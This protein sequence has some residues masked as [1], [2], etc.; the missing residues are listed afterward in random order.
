M[1]GNED[2]RRFGAMLCEAIGLDPAKVGRITVTVAA[3]EP[4]RFE[5]EGV[6]RFNDL[7]MASG[8][9]VKGAVAN[10]LQVIVDTTTPHGGTTYSLAPDVMQAPEGGE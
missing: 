2:G 9:F 6:V 4:V 7:L 8:E 3:D 5:A 1:R 10:G